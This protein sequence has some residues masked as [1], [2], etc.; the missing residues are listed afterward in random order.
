[1]KRTSI[2]KLLTTAMAVVMTASLPMGVHAYSITL[3]ADT[4]AIPYFEGGQWPSRGFSWQTTNNDDGTI[5][6]TAPDTVDGLSLK[7]MPLTPEET[8]QLNNNSF[9]YANFFKNHNLPLPE[10][11]KRM[12]AS[13][14][15]SAKPSDSSG[16]SNAHV[17]DYAWVR[18]TDATENT[19]AVLEYRCRACGDIAAYKS[20]DNSA[21]A[22]FLKDAAEEIKDAAANAVVKIDTVKWL[23]LDKA[24]VDAFDARKDVTLKITYT[25]KGERKALEIPAGTDLS[26]LLDENGYIGF[27]LLAEHYAVPYVYGK[28]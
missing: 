2:T 24:V 12:A 26:S 27:S 7:L 6:T 16:S 13:T 8:K 15:A 3:P 17:H 5:T 20:V 1:M 10:F 19:D 4:A 23:S 11:F 9:D 28:N 25:Q 21:Y 14:A 22:L 18:S